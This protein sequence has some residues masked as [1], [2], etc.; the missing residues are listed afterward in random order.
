MPGRN[1]ALRSV[2]T[3]LALLAL[4]LPAAGVQAGA[5]GAARLTH[6][7]FSVVDLDPGDG[8]APMWTAFSPMTSIS[9]GVGDNALPFPNSDSDGWGG[10]L[11][12]PGTA[13]ARLGVAEATA[14]SADPARTG[15]V[16]GL[17]QLK[18]DDHN[19]LA[20]IFF[21]P[22]RF[23][24]EPNTRL[25]VLGRVD[26]AV[27]SDGH[28]DAFAWASIS[29]DLTGAAGLPALRTDANVGAFL[30]AGQP[31]TDSDSGV[32]GWYVDNTDPVVTRSGLMSV[33]IGVQASSAG[34]VSS[35]AA[36]PLPVLAPPALTAPQ[37]P[38]ELLP[39]VPEPAS[40]ALLAVGLAAVGAA[41]RRRLTCPSCPS[42]R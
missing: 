9:V 4:L 14:S 22:S 20:S 41:A 18:V 40:W 19:G 11:G 10:A 5:S 2:P 33:D 7:G 28:S 1:H 3:G 39:A 17:A 34:G 30:R 29:F 6:L 25:V 8:R 42:A 35:G 32:F 26:L 21:T 23:S 38:P 15:H 37:I 27:Q 16:G 13:N 31:G 36:P 24:I 12:E